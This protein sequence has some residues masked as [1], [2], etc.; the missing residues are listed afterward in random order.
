MKTRI[1][2]GVLGIGLLA[3]ILFFYETFVLNLAVSIVC[4]AMVYEIF[5]ATK[6]IEKSFFMFVVSLLYS[7]LFPFLKTRYLG[8]YRVVLI[9][10]FVVFNILYLLKKSRQLRI[11]HVFFCCFFT[12]FV[13][14]FTI[15]IIY[16]RTVFHPYGIYYLILFFLIPWICDAGA[17]FVGFKFGKTKLAPNISPKK[18][19]EGAIGGAV[20]T[21]FFV[22]LYNFL[23]LYFFSVGVKLNLVSLIFATIFGILFSIVGDLSMSVFKRQNN[24]KDFGNILKGHG[25]VLDR[26]DSFIFVSAL[27]Y[28]YVK[29]FP[30]ILF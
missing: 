20:I 26:F 14:L 21:L 1:I 22:F 4:A 24:I 8:D 10:V 17:Y 6:M 23:F 2:T 11:Y 15:N 5:S 28:P 25:G 9:I 29:T 16:L 7:L 12:I 27:L 3:L 30:I 13:T 18:T 19:I